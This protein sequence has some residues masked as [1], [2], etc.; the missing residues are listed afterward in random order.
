MNQTLLNIQNSIFLK[1]IYFLL[2]A[3]IS[4]SKYI[5]FDILRLDTSNCKTVRFNKLP[6]ISGNNVLGRGQC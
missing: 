3:Q 5:I 6:G 1:K 4:N 2:Q